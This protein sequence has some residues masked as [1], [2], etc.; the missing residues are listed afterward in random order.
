VILA[1]VYNFPLPLLVHVGVNRHHSHLFLVLREQAAANLD[2]VSLK[3]IARKN[4]D[5]N[6]RAPGVKPIPIALKIPV[7]DWP[8][9][10]S[11]KSG[12]GNSKVG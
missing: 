5:K 6:R 10:F 2:V 3:I 12:A 9:N 4:F 11:G 7:P 1:L 8:E